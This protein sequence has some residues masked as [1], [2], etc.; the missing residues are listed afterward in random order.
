[1]SGAD[2]DGGGDDGNRSDDRNA[3][4]HQPWKSTDP[5]WPVED[6]ATQLQNPWFDAG[7]DRVRQ[8]DGTTGNYYWIEYFD[9]V[10]VVTHD[11]TTEELVMVEQ[12]RPRFRR[13]FVGCPAGGVEDG[14]DPET[15]ARRELREETGYRA[16]RVERL[17]SYHP[18][19]FD[20]MTRHVFYATDLTA[21]DTDPDDSEE[22][23]VVRRDPDV[24][25]ETA[26]SDTST[27]WTVTPLLW[28]R[29][30]DLL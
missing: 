16:E 27:G 4:D 30:E 10:A 28:A 19:G 26:L 24:A 5:K 6:V 20:R 11:R 23:T 14:E 21:G 9:A 18:S 29:E 15:A 1:M 25:V 12:Y 2:D 8:P 17:G 3:H 22:I 7:Y 13:R